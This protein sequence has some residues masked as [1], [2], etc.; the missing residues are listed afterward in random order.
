MIWRRKTSKYKDPNDEHE[1]IVVHKEEASAASVTRLVIAAVFIVL[2]AITIG[3]QLYFQGQREADRKAQAA[4]D[5]QFQNNQKAL[6]ARLQQQIDDADADRERLRNLIIGILTAKTP[7]ESRKLLEQF[8]AESRR[9]SKASSPG[10]SPQ[11]S[12]TTYRQN[13]QNSGTPARPSPRPSASRTTEPRPTQSP[14]PRP[15]PSPSCR[16]PRLVPLIP[17]V[18][19]VSV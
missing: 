5:I 13:R 6:N 8:I 16:I 7:T 17:C 1:I 14:S 18:Q 4:K 15:S 2:A 10:P 12:P 19:G 9:Q 3:Q 11:A